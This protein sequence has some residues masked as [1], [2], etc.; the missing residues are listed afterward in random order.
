MYI[1]YWSK[2]VLTSVIHSGGHLL[3]TIL[4]VPWALN[5]WTPKRMKLSHSNLFSFTV[6]DCQ[7]IEFRAAVENKVLRNHIIKSSQVTNEEICK[8][9]C[10]LEPSCV[11]YN[12]G[13]HNDGLFRCELSD[14]IHLQASTNE[15]ETRSGFIYRQILTVSKTYNW[16]CLL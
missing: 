8:I 14:K 4:F 2:V 1:S 13:P 7:Q 10:Y 5:S 12:Y 15:L 6:D 9:N 16:K 3:T 11:S